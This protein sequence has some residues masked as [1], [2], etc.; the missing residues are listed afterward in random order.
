M[1][2]ALLGKIDTSYHFVESHG[3]LCASALLYRT[4]VKISQMDTVHSHSRPVHVL[5]EM[6]EKTEY[7]EEQLQPLA[8]CCCDESMS[9]IRYQSAFS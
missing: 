4:M 3:F 9:E 2:Q 6:A 1:D 8:Q 7:A 5:G